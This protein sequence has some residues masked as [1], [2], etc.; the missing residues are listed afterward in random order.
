MIKGIKFGE[1]GQQEKGVGQRRLKRG[2]DGA[3]GRKPISMYDGKPLGWRTT[4]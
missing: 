3:V 1:P 2:P 4:P